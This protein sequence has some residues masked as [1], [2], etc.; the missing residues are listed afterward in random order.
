M[1]KGTKFIRPVFLTVVFYNHN[2]T[3]LGY[4]T[5]LP[6]SLCAKL[7]FEKTLGEF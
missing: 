3:I 7:N 2:Q 1:N 6:Q 4:V 5:P